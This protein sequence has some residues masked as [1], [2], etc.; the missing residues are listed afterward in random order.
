[1]AFLAT[2]SIGAIW[3]SC[4]PEFGVSSTLSR[5]K[6]I[7]PKI[8]FT[9]DGYQYNGKSFDKMETVKNLTG[10]L[11]SVEKV[12]VV[13]YL[14]QKPDTDG[15]GDIAFWE[16]GLQTTGELTIE[17]KPFSYTTWN[18]YFSRTIGYME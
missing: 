2:A 8:L 7:E 14:E 11:P 10:N 18:L 1:I 5:F 16:K 13:P 15:L 12:V 17:K 9:V 4:A 6:Q 3:S